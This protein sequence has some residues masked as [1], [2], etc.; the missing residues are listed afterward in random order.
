MKIVFQVLF[1]NIIGYSSWIRLDI[2][3]ETASIMQTGTAAY[4]P[5]VIADNPMQ[6]LLL[7]V[8]KLCYFLF[9]PFPW[10]VSEFRHLLGMLDGVVFI[11]LFLSIYSH[12]KYIKSNPQALILLLFVIFLS[13]VFSIAVGN[14]GTG[15]RHR[16]K[17]LP[18]IITIVA[19]F[20]YRVFFSKK[21]KSK[22][23]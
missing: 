7:L 18:I 9:S 10:D 2:L 15:L 19:P 6:F 12:R 1:D 11:M 21:K 5:W 22:L 14:F 23:E 16:S 3:V 4:P 13:L 20:I 8:P 17:M